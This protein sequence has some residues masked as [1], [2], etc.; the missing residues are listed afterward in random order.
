MADSARMNRFAP[1]LLAL[2]LFALFATT[3]CA[4]MPAASDSGWAALGEA[5][6]VGT[7]VVQ[8]LRVT[9]DSRC[10]MN[11]RCIWAGR[12]AV[13]ARIVQDGRTR[14]VTLH[15]DA[16][17]AVAGGVLAIDEIAPSSFMTNDHPVA[18]DYRFHF[19]FQ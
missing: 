15:S 11:A 4:T 17:L 13:E 10:P 1:A 5:T 8:P 6:R 7:V 9:E 16:P 3:A 2:P 19:A 14:N 18:G 12:V